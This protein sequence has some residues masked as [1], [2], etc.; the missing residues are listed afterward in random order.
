MIERAIAAALSPIQT[1]I[2]ALTLRVT[3]YASKQG[4]SSEVP[5][6]QAD[7]A[8][9]W[10]DVDYLKSIDFNDLM[11]TN[12]DRD[13]PGEAATVDGDVAVDE[14]MTAA[15]EEKNI[16][17]NLSNLVGTVV[18]PVIQASHVETSTTVPTGPGKPALDVTT[19][20]TDAQ[21]QTAT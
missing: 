4:K 10:R 8:G 15:Q 13:A 2:N 6:L 14:E 12:E 19:S 20:G 1:S 18:H 5:C 9:L 3:I 16:F 7:V 11:R 21:L 17:G